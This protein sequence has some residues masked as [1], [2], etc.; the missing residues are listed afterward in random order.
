MAEWLN[1]WTLKQLTR[2]TAYIC[3]HLY[4]TGDIRN[5]IQPHCH[6]PENHILHMGTSEP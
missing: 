5:S 3:Y 6:E 1:S 4:E 2:V